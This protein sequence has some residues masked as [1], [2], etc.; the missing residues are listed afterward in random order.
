[1]S[2]TTTSPHRVAGIVMRD[3]KVLL[4]HRV[5][6]HGEEYYCFPGG[7]QEPGETIEQAVVR[8][9]AEETSLQV[10]P[11]KLLYR[12]SWDIDGQNYFYLCDAAAGEAA[13]RT[14]SEEYAEVVSGRQVY[15]PVWVDIKDLPTLLVYQLEIRDLLVE[16]FAKGFVD[17]TKDLSIEI[18]KRRRE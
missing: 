18:E 8:E 3:S 2:Q 9:L 11:K 12:I 10:T 7:H 13:L 17:D 1:M 14:D 15:D 6:R 4:I 16:D 5:N